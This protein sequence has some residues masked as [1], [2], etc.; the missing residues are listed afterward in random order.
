[1]STN[2]R[3]PKNFMMQTT[4]IETPVISMSFTLSTL[5]H[6]AALREVLN[7]AVIPI[8]KMQETPADTGSAT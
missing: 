1:M 5:E 3:L 6:V 8:L 2:N 7:K 4:G